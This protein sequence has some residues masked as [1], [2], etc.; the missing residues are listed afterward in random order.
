[1]A[2][3]DFHTPHSPQVHRGQDEAAET[4]SWWPCS[5]GPARDSLMWPGSRETWYLTLHQ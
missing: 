4:I 3:F 5:A 2:Y 1:M